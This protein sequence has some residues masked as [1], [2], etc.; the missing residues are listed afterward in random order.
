MLTGHL[1]SAEKMQYIA[2]RCAEADPFLLQDLKDACPQGFT[3]SIDARERIPGSY[4]WQ[5][6]VES[7][8]CFFE[9]FREL[10]EMVQVKK[11]KDVTYEVPSVGMGRCG[12]AIRLCLDEK[13]WDTRAEGYVYFLRQPRK[14]NT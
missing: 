11:R 8:P 6:K 3:V 7:T 5:I 1:P 12:P 13:G 4:Y 14:E 9:D 2:R 10:W